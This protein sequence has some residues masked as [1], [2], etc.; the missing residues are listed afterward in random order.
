M[1]HANAPLTPVGRLLMVRR[2]EAGVP[3]AHVAR[4]MRLSLVVDTETLLFS[5]GLNTPGLPL[6]TVT[7][8][9]NEGNGRV[10]IDYGDHLG[11]HLDRDA[12]PIGERTDAVQD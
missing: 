8:I 11:E 12:D 7:D 5:T 10:T 6:R 4:Q 9:S 1:S 3:Q 2:V